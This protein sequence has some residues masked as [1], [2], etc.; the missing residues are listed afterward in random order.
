MDFPDLRALSFG[1]LLDRTFT[2]FRR[3]F[4]LFV[5]IM[6][7]PQA[8]ILVVN[9]AWAGFDRAYLMHAA[10]TPS[11]TQGARLIAPVLIGWIIVLIAYWAVA[12]PTAYGLAFMADLG[13]TG[14][15][16]GLA[17]GLGTAAA[18]LSARFFWRVREAQGRTGARAVPALVQPA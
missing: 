9:L 2:Y 18:L 6:A 15:W 10:G 11:P 8:V 3:H 7:V 16:I 13:A 14:I 4:W 1:E 17:V 12:L 5:T